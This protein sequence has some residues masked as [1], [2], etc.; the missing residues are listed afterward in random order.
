MLRV[1]AFKPEEPAIKMSLVRLYVRAGL[2]DKGFEEISKMRS[3]SPPPRPEEKLELVQYE[4]WAYA[5]KSELQKAEKALR[6]AMTE[7]P[8]GEALKNTLVEIYMST[9]RITNAF[10][11]LMEQIHAHPEDVNPM[12]NYSALKIRNREFNDAISMATQVLTLQPTNSYGLMNRAIASLQSGHLDEAEK[13]YLTLI[14]VLQ[15]PPYSIYYGLGEIA[16]QR[17][18]KKDALKNYDK[19]L[20]LI[21]SGSP[22][23]RIVKE[24]IKTLKSGIF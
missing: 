8:G 24:K 23:A 18:N 2:Y 22:E 12:I 9:G 3:G 20:E 13:D 14:S 1:L 16:Y 10:T 17:K 15:K 11:V 7:I 21:P 19:Y 4:A 6:T 5:G